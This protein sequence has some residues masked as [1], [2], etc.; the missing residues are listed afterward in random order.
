MEE[1]KYL[2]EHVPL[3]I[4]RGMCIAIFRGVKHCSIMSPT[5]LVQV[6][7]GAV[8]HVLKPGGGKRVV[9]VVV[10]NNDLIMK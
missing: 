5:A 10:N 9:E 3:W 8:T 4:R 1:M 7:T 2:A 6:H